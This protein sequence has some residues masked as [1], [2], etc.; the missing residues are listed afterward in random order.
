MK[1]YFYICNTFHVYILYIYINTDKCQ[2]VFQGF[3]KKQPS[4][5]SFPPL[6]SSSEANTSTPVFLPTTCL[7][8]C[9]RY[10]VIFLNPSHGMKWKIRVELFTCFLFPHTYFTSFQTPIE[11][12]SITPQALYP[13]VSIWNVAL[14]VCFIAAI[15]RFPLSII[16]AI[17]FQSSPVLISMFP[18]SQIFVFLCLF[19]P[20]LHHVFSTFSIHPL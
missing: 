20:V 18:G 15:L 14:G 16:F 5:C 19:L 6:T 12:N 7:C 9:K 1:I 3:Q 4:L 8:M 10:T 2:I 11:F 17:F 13:L